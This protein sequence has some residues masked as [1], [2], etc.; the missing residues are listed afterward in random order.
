MMNDACSHIG[1]NQNTQVN[2]KGYGMQI[3]QIILGGI[4][5]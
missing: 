4:Y 1:A 3:K 5:V 2:S